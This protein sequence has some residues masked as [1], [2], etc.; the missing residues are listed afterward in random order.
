MWGSLPSGL[1]KVVDGRKAHSPCWLMGRGSD[2][3]SVAFWGT[4]STRPS[5]CVA[6]E[7]QALGG[8]EE[9]CPLLLRPGPWASVMGAPRRGQM[10]EGAA[11]WGAR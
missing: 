2:I 4:D 8:L 11:F 1:L 6:S 3:L 7:D 10:L 9:C 5:S